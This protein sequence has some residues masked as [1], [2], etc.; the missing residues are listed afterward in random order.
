MY[1]LTVGRV[2]TTNLSQFNVCKLCLSHF[3]SQ[4]RLMFVTTVGIDNFDCTKMNAGFQKFTTCLCEGLIHK[5]KQALLAPPLP[6][7]SVNN[8]W[9]CS[10]YK[11]CLALLCTVLVQAQPS[12]RSTGPRSPTRLCIRS[13]DLGLLN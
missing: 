3:Q 6:L 2:L 9:L 1:T 7:M 4:D 12:T 13:Q 5:R 10:T 8:S 11:H